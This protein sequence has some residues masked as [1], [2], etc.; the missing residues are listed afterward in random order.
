MWTVETANVCMYLCMYTYFRMY[1]VCTVTISE[2][3]VTQRD[4]MCNFNEL[5]TVQIVPTIQM[6][7]NILQLK[8]DTYVGFHLFIYLY[9]LVVHTYVYLL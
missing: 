7:T 2:V 3:P 6:Y 4:T 8:I 5:Q 9:M 1:D